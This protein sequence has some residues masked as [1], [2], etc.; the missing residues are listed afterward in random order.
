MPIISVIM[1]V[2][3]TSPDYLEKAINSVLNQTISDFEFIVYNDGSNLACTNDLYKLSKIDCRIK[4]INCEKNNGLAFALNQCIKIANGDYIARMDSDDICSKY[5]FERQLNFLKENNLDLVG[6][7]MKYFD[8]SGIRGEENYVEF[9][10]K[11]D[12]LY[13]SPISHPTA[14]GKREVFLKLYNEKKYCGRVEDY[15][16]FMRV[17]FNRFN[18]GNLQEKLYFFRENNEAVARRKYKYRIHEFYIR[19]IWFSKL[20]LLIPKGIFY[21]FKPLLVGLIPKQIYFKIRKKRK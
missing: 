12:F 10:T 14:F 8:E 13:N 16:F 17:F 9:I 1:S 20:H 11:K 2:Y 15:E 21:C 19:L 4:F 5:R 7:C 18:L 6:C 3:N